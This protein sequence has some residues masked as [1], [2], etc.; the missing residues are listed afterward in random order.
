MGLAAAALTVGGAAVAFTGGA[1]V[2]DWWVGTPDADWWAEEDCAPEVIGFQ[3][4]TALNYLEYAVNVDGVVNDGDPNTFLRCHQRGHFQELRCMVGLADGTVAACS[5]R[6]G[7]HS[8]PESGDVVYINYSR[9]LTPSGS[10]PPVQKNGYA[11]CGIIVERSHGV[12]NPLCRAS[13]DGDGDGDGGDGD[14]S[15]SFPC[16]PETSVQLGPNVAH[17]VVVGSCYKYNKTQG[18]LRFAKWNGP[19]Y[20][21]QGEGSNGSPFSTQ[22]TGDFTA[23]SGVANGVAL[24][25]VSAATGG[26]TS[27]ELQVGDW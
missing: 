18:S 6:E 22:V 13:G 24:F 23:V 21:V 26:A 1:D 25:Y 10:N 2:Q 14:S 27:V 5:D 11:I 19:S 3:E 16:T 9:N 20:T 4:D 12:A 15:N 7:T 17:Q 8:L